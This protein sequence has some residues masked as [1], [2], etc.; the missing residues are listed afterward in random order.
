VTSKTAG[1]DTQDV[2]TASQRY[3]F[4]RAYEANAFHRFQLIGPSKLSSEARDRGVDC[5]AF[6][7]TFVPELERF[8]REGAF[9][10]VLFETVDSDGND[11]L[12]F[13]DE[14]EFR[15]W[16]EYAVDDGVTKAPRPLYS[17]WQ[18]LYLERCC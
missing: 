1:A 5:S 13:R 16:Q 17:P 7:S 4:R 3:G 6:S 15:P 12:V 8:D 11:L 18:L 14:V 10:P 2:T 9:R